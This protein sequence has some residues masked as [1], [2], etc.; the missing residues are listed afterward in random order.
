MS[1][2]RAVGA[3]MNSCLTSTSASG[4]G[5][6][7]DERL[8]P[9]LTIW[10]GMPS[11]PARVNTVCSGDVSRGVDAVETD[12]EGDSLD[13][14]RRRRTSSSSSRLRTSR[15][16]RYCLRWLRER[17]ADSRFRMTLA[18]FLAILA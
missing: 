17:C 16:A 8:T 14:P 18:S 11:S 7:T 10:G 9:E 15:P 13:C 12:F 1:E 2:L 3:E 6:A 5:G 4:G